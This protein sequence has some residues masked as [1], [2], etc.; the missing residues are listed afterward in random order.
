MEVPRTHSQELEEVQPAL[1]A[2]PRL[3]AVLQSLS[4][5]Q[6][7]EVLVT[8]GFT[9]W[10]QLL[11]I[12]ENDLEALHFKLGHRRKLQRE[13]AVCKDVTRLQNQLEKPKD[14]ATEI[15]AIQSSSV[16]R[17]EKRRM[18]QFEPF[19]GVHKRYVLDE[20]TTSSSIACPCY[21]ADNYTLGIRPLSRTDAL[22][23]W[24]FQEGTCHYDSVMINQI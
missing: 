5:D 10:D 15:A 21:S 3:C 19:Q 23:V 4:L 6:Y 2:S 7:T 8:H 9:S 24:Q 11:D 16:V 18:D 14:G 1:V 17:H 20:I 13:I 22:T 12:Q